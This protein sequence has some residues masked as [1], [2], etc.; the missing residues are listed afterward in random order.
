MSSLI[1]MNYSSPVTKLHTLA[2][3]IQGFADSALD[4][5][6]KGI[7]LWTAIWLKNFYGTGKRGLS[8]ATF[9]I[10]CRPKGS[11]QHKHPRWRSQKVWSP[12]DVP[13]RKEMVPIF[14][15]SAASTSVGTQNLRG[16]WV[17]SLDFTWFH[18]YADQWKTFIAEFFPLLPHKVMWSP[19][20]PV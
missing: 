17:L 3:V 11:A 6:L 8:P 9:T 13:V 2:S 4:D 1:K 16:M 12:C 18:V 15:L 14:W 5:T 19:S 10:T 20:H 7:W